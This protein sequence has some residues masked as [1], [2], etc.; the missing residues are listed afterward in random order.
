MLA[1]GTPHE[2]RELAGGAGRDM[3]AAFIAIVE[4]G[5]SGGGS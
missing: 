3:N 2:V 4:R 1:L 5:R